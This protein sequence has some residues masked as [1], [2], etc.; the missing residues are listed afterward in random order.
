[1]GR[2]YDLNKQRENEFLREHRIKEIVEKANKTSM[3]NRTIERHFEE[4]PI[5]E[6]NV[7]THAG[8]NLV[9]FSVRNRPDID[10]LAV[11]RKH[12]ETGEIKRH[13]IY[14]ALAQAIVDTA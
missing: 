4:A 5:L 13:D 3:L 8:E 12:L 6:E 1:M 7:Q 9:L 11:E 2:V 14:L 10:G